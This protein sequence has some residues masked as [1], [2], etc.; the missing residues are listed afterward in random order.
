[1]HA[2]TNMASL[3]EEDKRQERYI[4]VF[5]TYYVSMKP[6]IVSINRSYIES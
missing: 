1:M 6:S 5:L 3:V 4:I 2:K